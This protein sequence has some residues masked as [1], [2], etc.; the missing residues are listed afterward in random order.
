MKKTIRIATL[1][2]LVA[3]PAMAQVASEHPGATSSAGMPQ[4]DF[5]N[6]WTIAQ[7]VWMLIIFGAL[8]YVMAR[9][10]L[11]QVEGVLA[12][13]RARIE[14]DLETA[15]AAK[16]RA[17]AAMAEHQA[18]TARARAEAQAAINAATQKAQAEAATR[19]EALNAKLAAQI[20]AAETQIATARDN[21]MGALRQVATDTADA[22]VTRL[23]GQSDSAGVAAAVDRE[24][25]A[26]GQA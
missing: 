9:Y 26:R 13:R 7:V 25:A 24:L 5:G 21:A 2:S 4:L 14:G 19:A 8:Y 18:A 1:L 16:Q 23:M 22:L 3:L 17:D 20:A 12:A 6:P 15:Q 10:A 11:P